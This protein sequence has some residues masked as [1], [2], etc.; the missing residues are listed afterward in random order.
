MMIYINSECFPN[1][2]PAVAV[3]RLARVFLILNRCKRYLG[4][5]VMFVIKIA[6]Q[7]FCYGLYTT[8]LENSIEDYG[9]MKVTMKCDDIDGNT[10]G[11]GNSLGLF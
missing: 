1:G 7:E 3:R 4:G 6:E 8:I 5:I 9:T 2:V 11:E 10:K